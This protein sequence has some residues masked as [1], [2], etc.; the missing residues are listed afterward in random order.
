[1]ARMLKHTYEFARFNYRE[2]PGSTQQEAY[3]AVAICK[4]CGQVVV[5]QITYLGEECR[6]GVCYV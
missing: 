4:E 6:R 2:V 3:E 1:M 5:S